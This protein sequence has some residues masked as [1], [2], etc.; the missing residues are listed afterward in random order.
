MPHQSNEFRMESK[1]FSIGKG[2]IQVFFKM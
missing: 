1:E 2:E